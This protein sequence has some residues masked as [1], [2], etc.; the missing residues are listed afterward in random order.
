MGPSGFEIPPEAGRIQNTNRK[1]GGL[2]VKK[3]D[4][5]TIKSIVELE[6]KRSFNRGKPAEDEGNEAGMFR[7]TT[8]ADVFVLRRFLLK[9]KGRVG[10][11]SEP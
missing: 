1:N 8:D 3:Q 5:T 6:R 7:Y 11:G 9:R 4:A 2:H 10:N